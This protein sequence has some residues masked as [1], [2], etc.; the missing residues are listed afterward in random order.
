MSD[1]PTDELKSAAADDRTIVEDRNPTDT[2]TSIGNTAPLIGA[3][4]MAAALLEGCAKVGE[5]VGAAN[6]SSASPSGSPALATPV[7]A[8]WVAPSDAPYA[9]FLQQAQFSSTEAEIA[10]VKKKGFAG[11]LDEQMALPSS[12]GG[13][14][15]LYSRGYG[16]IDER[17]LAQQNS[18]A[19]Y[20]I[21]NQLIR[22]PDQVRRRIGLALS[23]YFVINT[24]NMTEPWFQA[25]HVARFYDILCNN[26]FGNFRKLLEEVT[27]S[28][29]MGA[30]LNTLR[31][32]KEDP[33]TGRLPDENYAR[34]VMQLFTIGVS[35]LNLDGTPKLDAQ[36]NPIDSYTQSDVTNLARVFTGYDTDITDGF[37]KSPVPPFFFTIP[38]VGYTK[39]PMKLQSFWHSDL[40]K[41]FL[42]TTIP[43]KT[44]GATSMRIALDTLFNH[45]N[46]GPFFSRQMIQRLVTSNPSGAYVQRVATVF[47]NNGS[48]VRGDLKAVFRAILLDD[49]AR[50]LANVSAPMFGKLREPMLR[51]AQWGRTFNLTSK[52]GTW[53]ISPPDYTYES[54]IQPPFRAP[55]VFNFFRPGYV[56]PN[57]RF[58]SEKATAPEFQI[59]NETTV[60]Q[61]INLMLR[62]ATS[63]L[64]V[65][66]PERI[67]D[68]FFPQDYGPD[69][70]KLDIEANYSTEYA[71]LSDPATLV[72]K[73]NL[74]LAAGRM[75]EQTE[76]TIVNMI[77][78]LS[79][80]GSSREQIMGT[81]ITAVMCCNEYIVQK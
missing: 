71:L 1:H 38:N 24:A 69:S 8:S 10:D 36:G 32:Q 79:A 74:V 55:S 57:T 35:Q 30:F 80:N 4:A 53:K 21:W 72:R 39:N 52:A 70:S 16:V 15:W 56:P 14:D 12:Q 49:E 67:D 81:V 13:W 51:F 28:V 48:G 73:L 66:L 77:K 23:E 7:A 40:E 65:H 34:E 11:W 20:M 59:V 68:G 31:N 6:G 37:S 64:W 58:A 5:S 54:I 27:L 46:V 29:A 19:D 2:T 62:V 43:A 76:T 75:T 78:S 25:F 47:N 60:S 9:R 26:A 22:S 3:V 33:N 44:D 18:G 50:N 45:P 61:Y 17:N 63:G 41:K 42:G